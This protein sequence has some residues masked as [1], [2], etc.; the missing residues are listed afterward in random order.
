MLSLP[1]AVPDSVRDQD[2]AADSG[3]AGVGVPVGP[4]VAG[5]GVPHRTGGENADL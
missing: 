3:R 1:K 2:H 5:G 4:G